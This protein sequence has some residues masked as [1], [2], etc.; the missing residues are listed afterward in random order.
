MDPEQ[1]VQGVQGLVGLV[2]AKVATGCDVLRCDATL[3]QQ[4][5]EAPR[6]L[7]SAVIVVVVVVVVFRA[8]AVAACGLRILL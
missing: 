8:D 3:S 6:Q 5:Q 4:L 1:A 2:K 7:C